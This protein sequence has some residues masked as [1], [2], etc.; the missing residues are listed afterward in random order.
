MGMPSYQTVNSTGTTDPVVMDWTLVPFNASFA[1]EL[2]G[3]TTATFAVQYTLD[4]VNG[5]NTVKW[6]ND[7]NVGANSTSS[8]AGNYVAPVRALRLNTSALSASGSII[9]AVLQGLPV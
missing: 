9:F 7:A 3:A 5:T 4:D 6:F 1:V 8:A 2:Q